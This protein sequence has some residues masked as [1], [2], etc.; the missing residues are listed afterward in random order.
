MSSVKAPPA[1][2]TASAPQRT[3]R[4][5]VSTGIFDHHPEIGDAIWLL[6]Y[7]IDKTTA[8]VPGANGKFTGIVLGGR[9]VRDREA[10]ERF[11]CAVKAVRRW[12]LRLEY[13]G[14]IRARRTP[15]GFVVEVVNSQK[16]HARGFD[17]NVQTRVPAAGTGIPQ[18]G[19][20]LPRNEVGCSPSGKYKEDK[21][22][23]DSTRHGQHGAARAAGP[24]AQYNR[25]PSRNSGPGLPTNPSAQRSNGRSADAN[26]NGLVPINEILEII[27]KAKAD[28]EAKHGK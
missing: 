2:H 3:F 14:Q 12:R 7:Y 18:T 5:P 4:I 20:P 8:E 21:T 13:H 22:R 17:K 9:P 15:F 23:M 11:S 19:R 6:L 16:W 10:A 24:T 25:M 27:R 1:A 28:F 26:E